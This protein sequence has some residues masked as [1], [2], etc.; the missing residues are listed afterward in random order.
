MEDTLQSV[1]LSDIV[2]AFILYKPE[3]RNFSH[4]KLLEVIHLQSDN[5]PVLKDI[6]MDTVYELLDTDINVL[7]GE[8]SL[9]SY[10]L[11]EVGKSRYNRS[12]VS[13]Y[14]IEILEALKIVAEESWERLKAR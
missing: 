2:R 4:D 13:D 12:L 7:M 5:Y 3:P 11:S 8:P 10:R 14:G 9:A 1:D 6:T